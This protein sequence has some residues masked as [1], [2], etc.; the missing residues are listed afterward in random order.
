MTDGNSYTGSLSPE[1]V[2]LGLL[3][4]NPH[5]GY[6][7]HNLLV[8]DLGQ[9][10]HI[11]LSQTYN[12]LNRLEA[13]G[14]IQGELQTQEK[15]PA[16][17][18]FHLTDLGRDRFDNWLNSSTGISVRHIRVEFIT[19]LYFASKYGSDKVDA[20]INCQLEDIQNGLV[21]LQRML[22]DL[23]LEHV[24][25]RLGLELR[26]NQLNAIRD[27]LDKCRTLS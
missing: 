25:N 15:L 6:E 2:F 8:A 19:R 4:S 13:Q 1:F 5:Y 9:I 18:Y 16:R 3:Q 11:S 20:L 24:F 17:R 12:I 7:L 22:D 21:R 14:Y 26:I 10:W 23:T 27:W